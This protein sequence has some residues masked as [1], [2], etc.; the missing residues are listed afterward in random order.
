M[1]Y[2]PLSQAALALLKH[3]EQG[4][5]GDFAATPY[6]CPAGRLTIGWGHVVRPGETFPRPLTDYDADEL[7]R[8]DLDRIAPSLA[9]ALRHRPEITRSMFAALLC[10]GFNIG[11]GA[12]LGSTLLIK[13]KKREW[14]A[15]ADQFLRWDKARNP[16]T[17]KP[18]R[19]PGLAR[20]RAAEREL[21]LC[22]GLP[23]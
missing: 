5:N 8:A 3:Y 4:P 18:E 23:P 6:R 14:Q 16:K 19:L 1:T 9:A 2:P 11:L 13:L 10:L 12:L 20:R 21:F 15:A 22:D 7:L 17:G